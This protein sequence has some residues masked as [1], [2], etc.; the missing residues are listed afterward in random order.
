M[1]GQQLFLQK[2]KHKLTLKPLTIESSGPGETKETSMGGPDQVLVLSVFFFSSISQA[3][4]AKLCSQVAMSESSAITG[5][6]SKK[7]MDHGE[8]E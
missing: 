7:K 8:M 2:C 4:A 1:P 6:L 5:I 3:R